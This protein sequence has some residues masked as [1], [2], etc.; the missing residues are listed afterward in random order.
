MLSDKA[1]VE[2]IKNGE[3]LLF[4]QGITAF[5][6]SI[7]QE[8]NPLDSLTIQGGNNKL[9]YSDFFFPFSPVRQQSRHAFFILSI[10]N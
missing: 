3:A 1:F 5:L 10:A 9:M 4:R 8:S 2:D 7:K 6:Y